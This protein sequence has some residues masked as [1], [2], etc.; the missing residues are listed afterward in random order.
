MGKRLILV[1]LVLLVLGLIA[2]GA[3]FA[4]PPSQEG[5]GQVEPTPP[6][7]IEPV[8]EEEEEVVEEVVETEDVGAMPA[9][10][11]TDEWAGA[12]TEFPDV[13]AAWKTQVARPGVY[14]FY[15][16]QNINPASYPGI[17]RGGHMTFSWR[18]IETSP[19][20]YN[21][22][23]VDSW[24]ANQAAL[25]KPVGLEIVAYVGASSYDPNV[26]GNV[27]PS[28]IPYKTCVDVH[29]R[30]FNVPRYHWATFQTQYRNLINAFGARYNNDERV[31]FIEVSTGTD[32]ENQA[33]QPQFM[34]GG[35]RSY[36][37]EECI[38][39]DGL[40]QYW[41]EEYMK[42]VVDYYRAAF[43]NKPLLIQ[44]YPVHVHDME[45]RTISQYAGP[46]GVGFKGNGLVADRDKAI[47]TG[48]SANHQ[49]SGL[50]APIIAYSTTVP[51]GYETYQFYLTDPVWQYW[52]V[53]NALDKRADYL[54]MDKDTFNDGDPIR[55][56]SLRF[57]NRYLGKDA[58]T[59][60][61]IWVAMRESGYTFYP[62]FGN[63]SFFLKQDDSVAGGRTRAVTYRPAGTGAYQIQ[64]TAMVDPSVGFLGTHKESWIT[65]RTDQ[66]TGNR[67]MW[68]KADNAYIYG[69]TNAI[70]ITVT[71]FDYGTDAWSLEYDGPG[72]AYTLATPNVVVKTNTSTWKKQTF[73]IDDA[74][75]ADGLLGGSDFRI[76]CKGDG[77]EYI[78]IVMLAKRSGQPTHDIAL[79]TG[80]NLVSIPLTTFSTALGDVLSSIAG[81]YT[82]VFAFDGGA[83]SWKSYDVSLP[84]WAN[85][86][87]NIDRTMGFWI[88][89]NSNETLTV[90][91][92]LPTTTSIP[93]YT[94]ANLIGFP[95][96]SAQPIADAL[97][98][99]A[100]QYSKVFE[101]DAASSSWKSYDVSLPGWANTLQQ[102]RPGY[103]YWIYVNNNCTL[104]ISN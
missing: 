99:I 81:K 57:A 73:Y 100:G 95:R 101:Y 94:G 24:I 68:F 1:I 77:D 38:I 39:A 88:Y 55:Q 31:E 10:E 11:P 52:A 27:A 61:D 9:D 75:M 104:T 74:R 20:V 76:D 33:V 3:V 5:D 45:R 66:A 8:I 90:V 23:V 93:L 69:G 84:G 82:K 67:Y 15:D 62:Q 29:G 92:Q 65:R 35:T 7:I 46:F 17:V 6:V 103:G 70:S 49:N 53:L 25:G 89:M 51:I 64:N 4:G 58:T 87:Q 41:W 85:T 60:P 96:S 102:M 97:S 44:H 34:A 98:S 63:Y 47:H 28:W 2:G 36:L 19:G 14:V 37:L 59:T 32:G 54:V 18:D 71:Y 50:D 42:R 26:R 48:S 78:H 43:S 22:A 12:S 83:K 21:W 80:A 79:K 30:E 16:Y 72:G 13:S 86:L 56:E 40:S 91:G